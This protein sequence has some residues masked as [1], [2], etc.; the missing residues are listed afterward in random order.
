MNKNLCYRFK[1]DT[2]LEPSDRVKIEAKPSN[3]DVV[4]T[5][6][7]ESLTLDDKGDIKATGKNPAG[8]ASASAKLNVIGKYY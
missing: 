7:I 8:E 5:L 6:T 1:G 2:K 4:S 3:G